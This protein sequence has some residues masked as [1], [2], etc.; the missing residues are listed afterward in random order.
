MTERHITVIG[1]DSPESEMCDVLLRDGD[2][3]YRAR[4]ALARRKQP[5][6]FPGTYLLELFTEGRRHQYLT[7]SRV[8]DLRHVL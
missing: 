1:V 7:E 3:E 5:L 4:I 6:D 8:A 2:T